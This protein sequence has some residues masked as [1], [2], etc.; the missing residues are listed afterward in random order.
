MLVPFNIYLYPT[1]NRFN[2]NSIL[3]I[4]VCS[5]KYFSHSKLL[6]AF[7]ICVYCVGRY[8]I[9]III[10]MIQKNMSLTVRL[11]SVPFWINTW[12][13][14]FILI[15]IILFIIK[16]IIVTEIHDWD[17]NTSLDLKVYIKPN[18]KSYIVQPKLSKIS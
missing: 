6:V 10:V 14:F 5:Y 11:M 3:H 4:L 9:Y 7:Y 12:K 18:Q 2:S 1:N 15:F 16:N 13:K 8:Y 17:S